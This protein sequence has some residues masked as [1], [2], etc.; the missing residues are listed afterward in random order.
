[1]CGFLHERHAE[2]PSLFGT[3]ADKYRVLMQDFT[4]WCMRIIQGKNWDEDGNLATDME[5][6]WDPVIMILLNVRAF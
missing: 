2:K 1:M 5:K 3:P 6:L 4:F